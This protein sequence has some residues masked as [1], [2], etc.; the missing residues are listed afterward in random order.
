[1]IEMA[2]FV[3]SFKIDKDYER[4][5]ITREKSWIVVLCNR[6]TGF[7]KGLEIYGINNQ[8]NNWIK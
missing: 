3:H 2:M 5:N 6:I 7:I 1:M 4:I 8:I